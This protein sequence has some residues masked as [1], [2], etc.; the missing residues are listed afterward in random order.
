MT[1]QFVGK[2]LSNNILLE[3]I[4]Q[5][6][7]DVLFFVEKGLGIHVQRILKMNRCLYTGGN[8]LTYCLE[9]IEG[10]L[11]TLF[12]IMFLQINDLVPTFFYQNILCDHCLYD[13]RLYIRK[14][15]TNRE[16]VNF[17]KWNF[18]RFFFILLLNIVS[19]QQHEICIL[20]ICFALFVANN[21]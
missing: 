14:M 17:Q 4:I 12:T 5:R 7:L 6:L 15:L 10:K 2:M 19:L 18:L 1:S 13:L 9:K 8:F 20:S 16:M 3:T 21:V 11:W